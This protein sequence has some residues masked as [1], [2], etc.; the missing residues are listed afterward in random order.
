MLH[1][2]ALTPAACS[3]LAHLQS[4]QATGGDA[5]G[6]TIPR[7]PATIYTRLVAARMDSQGVVYGSNG[8][9][10]RKVILTW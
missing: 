4:H 10:L 8:Q 6:A 7:S 5:I 1:D 9:P 2:A 3:V